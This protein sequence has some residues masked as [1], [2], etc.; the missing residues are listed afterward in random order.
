MYYVYDFANGQ[1]YPFETKEELALWW[2][3]R[4]QDFNEL[5]V[6]EPALYPLPSGMGI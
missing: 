2:L 1:S 5:N 6:T 4:D 3:G